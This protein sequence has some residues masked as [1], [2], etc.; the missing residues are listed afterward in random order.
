MTRGLVSDALKTAGFEV[1]AV[2]TAKEAVQNFD[3]IDPD[4]LI[5]D[6]HLGAPPSGSE[7]ALVLA[8][9]APHLAVVLMSN[10][11]SAH[12]KNK[13]HG[14]P[15]HTVVASKQQLVDASILIEVVESALRNKSPTALDSEANGV[16]SDLVASL[17]PGQIDVWR[18]LASGLSNQQ[19]AHL[20]GTTIAATERL[21]T[22][23]FSR[24]QLD[25]NPKIN[26]RVSAA[27][28]YIALYGPPDPEL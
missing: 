6:V 18:M 28:T 27:R 24:L 22:R 3:R 21:V 5:A 26:S 2:P 20:R 8:T 25:G 11:P 4:V 7:L 10:Y 1:H 15:A 9:K 17:T 12:V 14:L 19:I 16:A 13:A 23:L